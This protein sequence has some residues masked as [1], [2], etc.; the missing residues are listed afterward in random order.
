VAVRVKKTRICIPR[1]GFEPVTVTS[2]R[3]NTVCTSTKIR[4]KVEIHSIK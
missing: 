3:P 4:Q 2:A 1:T